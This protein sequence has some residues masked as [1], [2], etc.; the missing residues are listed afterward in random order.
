MLK[1]ITKKI[2]DLITPDDKPK[3]Y[4]KTGDKG[5]TSLVDGTRVKK[6]N[7]R[8]EAYGTID[9]LGSFIGLAICSIQ[10]EN[11]KETLIDIQQELFNIGSR[12]ATPK[13]NDFFGVFTEEKYKQLEKEIDAIE[14]NL[15]PLTEFILQGG[16]EVAARLHIA[17]T[18]ARRAERVI[19]R[20]SENAE[21]DHNL[22][23]YMNRLSDLLFVMARHEN[24]GEDVVWT[25]KNQ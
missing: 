4:T 19:L 13:P 21:V 23:V 16:S 18:V 12:L 11:I 7:D 1:K 5:I 15:N 10:D 20:L 6:H 25:N 3:I 8:V 17:R 22:I 14:A 24:N 2:I 9:E